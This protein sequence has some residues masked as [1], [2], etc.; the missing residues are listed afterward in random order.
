MRSGKKSCKFVMEDLRKAPLCPVPEV[1]FRVRTDLIDWL[2]LLLY[3]HEDAAVSFLRRAL[4]LCACSIILI[5]TS[6][7]K[8]APWE[9]LTPQYSDKNPPP[10]YSISSIETTQNLNSIA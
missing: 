6:G 5:L 7:C 3:G 4:V 8:Q 2:R 10:S 1:N 9:S